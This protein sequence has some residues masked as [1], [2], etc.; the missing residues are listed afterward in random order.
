MALF[1]TPSFCYYF[2][3]LFVS[4]LSYVPFTFNTPIQL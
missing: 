3:R 1:I 2:V 4:P